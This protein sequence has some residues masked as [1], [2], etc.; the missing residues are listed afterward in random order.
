[1]SSDR[2]WAAERSLRLRRAFGARLGAR[3]WGE[4]RASPAHLCSGVSPACAPG[5]AGG[6]RDYRPQDPR[7]LAPGQGGGSGAGH[8]PPTVAADD[9]GVLIVSAVALQPAQGRAV[10][11]R[12]LRPRALHLVQHDRARSW[13]DDREAGD[14]GG[15]G[16]GSQPQ[17]AGAAN[18]AVPRGAG[19]DGRRRGW[20]PCLARLR[21]ARPPRG[22]S[23]VG[24]RVCLQPDAIG[25]LLG[26]GLGFIIAASSPELARLPTRPVLRGRAAEN[27]GVP[28]MGHRP[29][30]RSL[31]P[32]LRE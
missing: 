27:L 15:G 28:S 30:G 5:G 3:R 10:G 2:A 7:T 8:A 20:Q 4:R 9:A 14:W 6:G 17:R 18:R 16:G 1:M 26:W 13:R 23:R 31:C 11:Q 25:W 19:E 32:A 24:A 21:S 29:R 22:C 12:G